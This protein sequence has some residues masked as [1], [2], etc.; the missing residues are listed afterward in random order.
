MIGALILIDYRR[1]N[2]LNIFFFWILEGITIILSCVSFSRSI[3]YVSKDDIN[4]NGLA[5]ILALFLICIVNIIL[6][7]IVSFYC[8]CNYKNTNIKIDEFIIKK[9]DFKALKFLKIGAYVFIFYLIRDYVVNYTLFYFWE[10]I[11][12]LSTIALTFFYCMWAVIAYNK[13][14]YRIVK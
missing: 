9:D 3:D 2:R 8:F 13:R 5:Y 7:L 10:F 11:F 1:V 12:Y 14:K 6:Y 4:S